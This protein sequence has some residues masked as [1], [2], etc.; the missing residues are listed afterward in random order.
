MDLVHNL[1]D[2]DRLQEAGATARQAI[3]NGFDSSSL[4]LNLYQLAF[5]DND[6][7]EMARQAA[8]LTSKPG[9]EGQILELEAEAAAYWGHLKE[10]RNLSRLAVASAMR[11]EESEIA[12]SFKAN[13]A[14]R[15]ALLGRTAEVRLHAEPTYGVSMGRGTRYAAALSFA[16]AGDSL[17][18]QLLAD[19]L[20]RR[21][22][23]DTIVNFNYLPTIRAQIALDRKDPARAIELLQ[24][25]DPTNWVAWVA[26]GGSCFWDRCMCVARRIL[27]NIRD[28]KLPA[29]SRRFSTTGE[30][31]ALAP[32]ARWNICKS[33]ERTAY[34][35]TRRR[36]KVRTRI[37]SRSGKTPTP[38]SRFSS[39]PKRNTRSCSSLGLRRRT[40]RLF[41]S[42][43]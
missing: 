24:S 17:R 32:S 20:A 26:Y 35:E 14:L 29:N 27:L 41:V 9:S 12:T 19:D 25:A 4:R 11:A 13:A 37:S 8:W 5:L 6:A 28:V 1:L 34:Q 33:G 42:D 3:A 22:P 43:G 36:Q 10:S 2:L 39:K 40:R 16:L 7:S 23:D 18:A 31:S 30:L 15:E 38:T 21:Y